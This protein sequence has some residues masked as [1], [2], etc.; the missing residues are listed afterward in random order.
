[1]QRPSLPM[2]LRV[3]GQRTLSEV[4][5]G[6]SALLR[7]AR[8]VV[9]TGEFRGKSISLGVSQQPGEPW[10]REALR[11][12]WSVLQRDS[13]GKALLHGAGDLFFSVVLPRSPEGGLHRPLA[14][15]YRRF[16]AGIVRALGRHGIE[17]E[18]RPGPQLSEAYCLLSGQGE[19]LWTR[20]RIVGGASQ[21]LTAKGLLHHGFLA[22][23][24]DSEGLSRIFGIPPETSGTWLTG[25]CAEG[26][27]VDAPSP[28]ELGGAIRESLAEDPG[29]A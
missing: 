26:L 14:G 29:W 28:E 4:L 6:D 16:G 2:A 7:A 11:E 13:G 8:P 12:G 25:L 18:W 17:T 5:A 24:V 21:H 22:R 27:P 3:E 10:A 9:R 23:R 20:S 1:M 19:V 15:S